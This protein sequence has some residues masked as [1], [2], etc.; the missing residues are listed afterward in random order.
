MRK[1]DLQ[2]LMRELQKIYLKASKLNERTSKE[3]SIIR[4]EIVRVAKEISKLLPEKVAG[5]AG[6]SR[7]EK[8]V[9]YEKARRIAMSA[10]AI[11]SS[12]LQRVLG[13]GYARAAHLV[14]LLEENG[15]ISGAKGSYPREIL[16]SPEKLKVLKQIEKNMKNQTRKEGDSKPKG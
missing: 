3:V 11:T 4:M 15:V 14:D 9:L 10:G 2:A 12:H 5:G 13:I 1:K 16:L 6:V 7:A 8:D